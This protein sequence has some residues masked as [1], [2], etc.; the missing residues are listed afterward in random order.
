M[1][2]SRTGSLSCEAAQKDGGALTGSP[3]RPHTKMA[4]PARKFAGATLKMAP[5]G[6]ELSPPHAK[7]GERR[8]RQVRGRRQAPARAAGLGAAARGSGARTPGRQRGPARR[9]P[10]SAPLP[11]PP[12]SVPLCPGDAVGAA[13]PPSPPGSDPR[14][15]IRRRA[16]Q[17]IVPGV[18]GARRGRGRSSAS[19]AAIGDCRQGKRQ[20]MK[21][22]E[23]RQ[24]ASRDVILDTPGQME[25]FA[26]SASGT[27]LTEASASSFPSVALCVPDTSGRTNPMAFM[28]NVLY[29]CR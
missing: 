15:Q 12:R 5:P 2:T 18:S 28:S 11:F 16:L 8:G 9:P 7:D 21:L 26:W 10:R 23:K 25:V 24:N 14:R 29:A 4:A 17:E 27:I 1:A 6:P 20:V 19:P 22:L 13:P 3:P